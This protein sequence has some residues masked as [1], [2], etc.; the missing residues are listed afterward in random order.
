MAQIPDGTGGE[1]VTPKRRGR[2]A[3]RRQVTTSRSG[4]GTGM[5]TTPRP[6]TVNQGGLPT[7]TAEQAYQLGIRH[8]CEL[9]G[10]AWPALTKR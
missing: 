6:A 9:G 3:R 8:G 5:G 7:L 2:Q 1:T 10:I 4:A